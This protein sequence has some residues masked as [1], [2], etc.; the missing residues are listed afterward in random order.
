[1]RCPIRLEA[2]TLGS[3]VLTLLTT[4]GVRTT[5]ILRR[6]GSERRGGSRGGQVF[7]TFLT[8]SLSGLLELQGR[9]ELLDAYEARSG[10]SSTSIDS[11]TALVRTEKVF[12][13]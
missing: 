2:T 5:L 11:T 4:V 9:E 12:G 1:M 13:L 6:S 7:P 10:A 8:I 3:L